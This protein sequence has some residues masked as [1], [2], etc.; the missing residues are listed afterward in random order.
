VE[1]AGDLVEL[2]LE[3]LVDR[4]RVLE[5]EAALEVEAELELVGE[6]LRDPLWDRELG[7]ICDRRQHHQGAEGQQQRQEERLQLEEPAH[8]R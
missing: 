1:L 5:V 4:D 8:G 3:G 2:V 6:S 7:D